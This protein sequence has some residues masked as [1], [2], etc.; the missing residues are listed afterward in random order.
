M[1]RHQEIALTFARQF[2]L[3]RSSR[4]WA[5]C[6][7]ESIIA[8]S[9]SYSSIASPSIDDCCAASRFVGA[10]FRGYS[11]RAML[12]VRHEYSQAMCK[13]ANYFWAT[14]QRAVPD[15]GGRPMVLG[16]LE[17]RIGLLKWPRELFR[18][19]RGIQCMAERLSLTRPYACCFKLVDSATH[20]RPL[21]PG[22]W[23]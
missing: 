7:F 11:A 8:S 23:E 1:S 10:V 17:Q 9:D 13:R 12:G 3:S 18:D 2:I 20:A 5:T 14:L 15:L 6:S 22:H 16:R 21:V 19:H 4:F